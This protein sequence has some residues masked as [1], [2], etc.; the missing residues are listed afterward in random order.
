MRLAA[1][2]RAN[3]EA[4]VVEFAGFARTMVPPAATMSDVAL[5]DHAQ[6]ILLAIASDMETGQSGAGRLAKSLATGA[7]AAKPLAGTSAAAH[8]TMRQLA[9]FDLKQLVAEFRALRAAVLRRW[10]DLGMLDDHDAVEDLVRFNEGI[11][12][13]V[14]ESVDAYSARVAESR[15]L[16]LAV[17]G[18]DLRT[19][20]GALSA[21][22]HLLAKFDPAAPQREKAFAIANRSV[23]NIDRMITDLLEYT[24]TRLG[25]GI[26]VTPT[27][28]DFAALCSDTFD[29]MRAAYASRTLELEMS[30]D[31]AIA[32]D[33]P[34]MRQVLTNLLG[35]AVQHGDAAWPVRMTVAGGDAEVLLAVRNRGVPIPADSLQVIFDPLVQVAKH[36]AVAGERPSTSLGLGLFIAREIVTAHG[37][38]IAVESSVDAGTVFTVRLQRA[39]RETRGRT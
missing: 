12:Q 22:L 20:L 16:F 8:G 28:G 37:G 21:C 29:E 31:L 1:C 10:R 13:A 2:I 14:A 15:E 30:G 3:V 9:G 33:G 23:A 34:R 39:V 11:D 18:H 24:R 36:K 5:R 7:G 32:F 19:P 4:I 17:L 27:V 25:R 26:E 35:N 38:R 6:Q